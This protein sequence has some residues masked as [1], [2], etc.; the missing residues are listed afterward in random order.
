MPS[1]RHVPCPTKRE[2]VHVP[3]FPH[4]CPHEGPPAAVSHAKVFRRHPPAGLLRMPPCGP[5]PQSLE[6]RCVHVVEGDLAD[7]VAVI[8]GPSPD[9]GVELGYQ[10]PSGGLLVRL[11]DLPD[12]TVECADILSVW[13]D[14]ELLFIFHF[15]MC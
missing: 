9:D 4:A 10:M 3:M 8:V 5:R 15:F 13:F 2:F 12:M 6:D 14:D 7:H 11:H 1:D